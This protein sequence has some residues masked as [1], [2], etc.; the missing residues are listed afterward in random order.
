MTVLLWNIEKT[1]SDRKKYN[2]QRPG[3][4]LNN[5]SIFIIILIGSTMRSNGTHELFVQYV[6]YYVIIAYYT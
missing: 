3:R 4:R 2:Q 1:I 5:N 6:I